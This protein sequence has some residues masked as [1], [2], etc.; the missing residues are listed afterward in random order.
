MVSKVKDFLTDNDFINYVLDAT[1]EQVSQWEAYFRVH[2]EYVVVAE[3][4][5]AVLLAPADVNC[6]FTIG[7][8]NGLKN[9]IIS[10]ID[11]FQSRLYT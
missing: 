5:K 3:E 6:G 8:C 10:S 9:R 7:E 1:P 4:A 11:S 2:P